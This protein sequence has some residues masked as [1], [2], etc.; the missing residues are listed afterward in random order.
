MFDESAYELYIR[1]DGAIVQFDTYANLLKRIRRF[2]DI[3]IVGVRI[4]GYTDE[5]LWI[6]LGENFYLDKLNG[7][8]I[9]DITYDTSTPELSFEQFKMSVSIAID[10]TK[11]LNPNINIPGVVLKTLAFFIAEAARFEIIEH[12]CYVLFNQEDKTC[13]WVDWRPMLDWGKL[14]TYGHVHITKEHEKVLQA[15]IDIAVSQQNI[16]DVP[17][18]TGTASGKLRALHADFESLYLHIIDLQPA[19]YGSPAIH[20]KF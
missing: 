7:V 13:A 2:D 17:Y 3:L 18:V 1:E 20:L 6:T 19:V 12:T 8:K 4:P 14:S 10:L 11:S 16:Y 15:P 9:Q 5:I